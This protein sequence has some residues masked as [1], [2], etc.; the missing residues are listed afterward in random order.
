METIWKLTSGKSWSKIFSMMLNIPA[1]NP[2][3]EEDPKT[4]NKTALYDNHVARGAKMVDF[5]GWQMPLQYTKVLE[6]HHTVRQAV[7]LFDI[8]HMGLVTVTTGDIEITR[9]FLDSLVPQ[10]LDRLYQGK[11]V[12]TQL[13]NEQGGIIDDIIVYMLPEPLQK[14]TAFQEFLLICN[15]S[16]TDKDMAWIRQHADAHNIAGLNVELHSRQYSLFALQGPNF[17]D[18]L[19]RTGFDT[20]HLPKRFH[21]AEAVIQEVPVMLSRT[22]YTGE[23]G[24]EIIVPLDQTAWLWDLLLDLGKPNG[25]QPIGLGARDTLR[26]EAAYPLHGHDISEQDTPLEAGLQWSVKLEKPGK[27][28]GKDALLLQQQQGTDKEFVCFTLNKRTI[29]RQHDIILKDGKPI[30]AVTSGSI[31]PTFNLP[32]GMGYIHS[33]VM[34]VPGDMIQIRVRGLEVDAEIVERPFYQN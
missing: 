7:G 6:E 13:L 30:G 23:D 24:V 1:G 3:P 32:I 27:F 18:V 9:A 26:L 29:A 2:F 14:L 8:S 28:I 21:I 11:A 34:L 4:E 15:A 10:R 16:N 31:S 5:A 12:Y 17:A 22:G 33:D 19:A 20:D 25:I